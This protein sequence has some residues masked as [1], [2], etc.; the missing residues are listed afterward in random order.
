[1]STK[2]TPVR[3]DGEART[4]EQLNILGLFDAFD[5]EGGFEE[6]IEPGPLRNTYRAQRTLKAVWR[7]AER[8]GSLD[9]SLEQ[10]L[11]D[12]FGDLMHLCDLM[13]AGF[14]FNSIS[15]QARARYVEE[16]NGE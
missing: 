1:M 4:E 8:C 9:D 16:V 11:A 10:T 6:D 12:L 2:Q 5:G 14:D 7:Y 13:G 3:L 15:D